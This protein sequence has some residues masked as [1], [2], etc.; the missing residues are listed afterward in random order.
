[1][2]YPFLH[3]AEKVNNLQVH[4]LIFLKLIAYNGDEEGSIRDVGAREP[5]CRDGG[6]GTCHVE[7]RPW[8]V[9][10][11]TD[12]REEWVRGPRQPVLLGF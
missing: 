8:P 2:I 11:T 5:G 9:R 3:V 4:R 7:L 12:S 10:L 1:M 6:M